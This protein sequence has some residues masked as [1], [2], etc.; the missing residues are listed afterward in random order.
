MNKNKELLIITKNKRSPLLGWWRVS[1]KDKKRVI[2][3]FK[4]KSEAIGYTKIITK[5]FNG[6]II[7]KERA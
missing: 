5:L 4:I 2:A 6:R 3:L 1:T 7:W